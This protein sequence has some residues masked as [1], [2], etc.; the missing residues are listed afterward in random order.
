MTRINLVPV[1]EL[2]DQHLLA[3]HREIKRIPNAITSW[4][5]SIS[6]MPNKY[7]MWKWHIKFFYNKLLFLRNRYNML[8]DEC[9]KRWFNVSCYINSFILYEW[10]NN[11]YN[12]D[13]EAINI[14]RNRIN[15][16]LSIKRGFYRKN[17]VLI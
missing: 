4:K 8:F 12:P 17:G 11:D 1:D 2:T 3:E 13:N 6:W 9:I 15:E 16:K 10:L 5:Y 14:S 7:T